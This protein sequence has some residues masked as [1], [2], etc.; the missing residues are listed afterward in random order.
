MTNQST[1]EF[2]FGPPP[3]QGG[4]TVKQLRQQVQE[5]LVVIDTA[6]SLL[7]TATSELEQVGRDENLTSIPSYRWVT[8]WTNET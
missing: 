5:L 6:Q 2:D 4:E 1:D 7:R 3:E 8:N